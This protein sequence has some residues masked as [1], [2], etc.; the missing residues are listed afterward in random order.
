MIKKTILILL[1]QFFATSSTMLFAQ[2]EDQVGDYEFRFE[3]INGIVI[4][5]LSLNTNGTFLFHSYRKLDGG[6]PPEENEYAKGTWEADKKL[7]YFSVDS[8]DLDDEY[9][10]NFNNSKARFKSK[11][12][13]DKSNRVVETSIRFYESEI[14][15]LKGKELL[16]KE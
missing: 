3:G 16:K 6:I 5:K 13:R 8:S 2:S 1:I 14:P 12:P 15:W 7:I 9:I 10:L 11:S 4:Y